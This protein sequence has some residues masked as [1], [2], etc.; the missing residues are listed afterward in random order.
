MTAICSFFLET[1]ALGPGHP[2]YLSGSIQGWV[3][4]PVCCQH[5]A[6]VGSS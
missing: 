6:Q 2:G 5:A 1:E 4:L 3:V